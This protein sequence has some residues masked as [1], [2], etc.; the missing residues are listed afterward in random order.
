M[1]TDKS[2]RQHYDKGKIVD[3]FRKGLETITGKAA[4]VKG[5]IQKGFAPKTKEE[6]TGTFD[7]QSMVKSHAKSAIKTKIQ[8][9]ILSKLGLSFLNPYIG[10]ASLFGYRPSDLMQGFAPGL[11]TGQTQAQYEAARAARQTQARI[12]NLLSR[13]SAGKTYSQKNLNQLTM[14][15]RPGHYDLPGGGGAAADTS[16]STPGNNPWGR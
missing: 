8:D 4:D 3:H 1:A 12:D 13:K 9:A 2:L 15:S 6:K 11:K 10:L 14:G 7:L 16:P 5:A